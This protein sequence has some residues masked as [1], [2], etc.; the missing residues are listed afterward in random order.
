M[1]IDL[2]QHPHRRFNPLTGEWILVSPQRTQRPWLGQVEKLPP[3]QL[4]AYD[5]GCYMCPGNARATGARNPDYEHTFVFE[6][7]Y[8]ALVQGTPEGRMNEDNLLVAQTESGVCRV[9]C[10]SPRHDL[11]LAQMELPDLHRVVETWVAQYQE[12]GQLSSVNYVL[13]F[14][15]RGAMIG[16]SNPHPHGQ[17]WGCSSIPDE[18]AKET[19]AQRKHFEPDKRCLLCDY[20]ATERRL[21]E[22]VIFENSDFCVLVPFWAVWPFETMLLPLRHVPAMTELTL[23]EQHSL[24]AALQ[25]LTRTYNRLFDVAFPYSMG[26]HQQPTDAGAYPEWHLH[27]HFYPPLL[28][29]ATI[30]KFMVGFE[31]LGTPQR[32]ITPESAAGRLRDVANQAP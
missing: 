21:A 2:K 15:N 14:E 5:P 29:S 22:R 23:Q 20:V 10:F 8:P 18:P 32:D 24:A 19:L 25:R 7:D 26:F 3:E 9:V 11:T 31:M 27:A 1:V 28:R 12:L 6:N 16:A 4:P 17:I 13:A 30:R